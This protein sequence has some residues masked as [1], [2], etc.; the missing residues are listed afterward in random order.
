[1]IILSV[2]PLRIAAP[3]DF[4]AARGGLRDIIKYPVKVKVNDR[5]PGRPPD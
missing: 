4:S 5:E 2:V 3:S 1:M